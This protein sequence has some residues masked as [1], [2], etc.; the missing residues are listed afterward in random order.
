MNFCPVGEIYTIK[1]SWVLEEMML[2]E[3]VN[4][5]AGDEYQKYMIN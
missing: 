4:V 2:K 1:N 5:K 3:I